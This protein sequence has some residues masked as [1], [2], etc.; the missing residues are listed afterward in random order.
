MGSESE[1]PPRSHAEGGKGHGTREASGRRCET[2]A[3]AEGASNKV[4]G[5]R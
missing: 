3:L 4:R 2:V 5:L 1:L